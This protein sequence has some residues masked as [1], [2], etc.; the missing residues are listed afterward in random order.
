MKSVLVTGGAG[1][2]G[3]HMV[4]LLGENTDYEITVIDNL[5]TGNREAVLYGDLMAEDISNSDALSQILSKRRFDAV[6]HFAAS[7][8]VSESMRDPLKYYS[9]NVI[10]TIEL[11]KM[12]L[13]YG[14]KYFILSS[15]AAVYGMPDTIPIR[16]TAHTEP[17]NPYGISK[18]TA[19]RVLMDTANAHKG[20]KYVI[21]RYFNVAGASPD[22]K[23]G[24]SFP[25]ATHLVKKAAQTASG[26][27]DCMYIYGTDYDTPDGTAVRDY[28]HVQ[29]LVTA[30]LS[31]L[32]YLMKGNNS[33][34]FN[35]GYGKGYS[36]R[37]V[38]R[39]MKEVS[40]VDFP[41]R[42]SGRRPGDAPILVSDN[43]KISKSLNW[44][45]GYNNLAIIC[46]TALEWE[47]KLP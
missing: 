20:L 29:D 19:E 1:Y 13:R 30:H 44:V 2:I 18:L 33:D 24:Q 26:K 41:T 7:I 40:G 10:N 37:E 42:E 28:I 8:I 25:V 46:K 22:G 35:C 36:V 32:E 16:E 23:I 6:I 5:S 9:N 34:I 39:A 15:T 38:I 4:K 43:S 47:K 14:V 3:S 21:L 17:I 27:A 45:P 11:I 31:S 12:S